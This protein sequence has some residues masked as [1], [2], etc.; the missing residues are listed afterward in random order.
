MALDNFTIKHSRWDSVR[1]L[2]DEEAGRLFKAL[3]RYDMAEEVPEFTDR[4]IRSVFNS[5]REDLDI[6]QNLK[7]EYRERQRLK[8]IIR[9]AG[10]NTNL[11]QAAKARLDWLSEKGNSLEEY[12]II[13]PELSA[14][15]ASTGKP[16]L[17]ADSRNSLNSIVSNSNVS[18]RN[19]LYQTVAERSEKNSSIEEHSHGEGCDSLPGSALDAS[20]EVATVPNDD[21]TLDLTL[22]RLGVKQIRNYIVEIKF[23]AKKRDYKAV[24]DDKG[25]YTSLDDYFREIVKGI[26]EGRY[27]DGETH[28]EDIH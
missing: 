4:F 3:F 8:G 21:D 17:T 14:S 2:T 12:F 28:T 18:E 25:P 20:G 16:Q 6:N 5:F 23:Y 7:R 24:L 9:Q 27:K 26:D 15:T 10:D 13:F 11:R 1:D 19:A 22:Q